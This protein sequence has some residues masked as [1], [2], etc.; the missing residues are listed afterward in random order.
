[1][2]FVA[3]YGAIPGPPGGPGP[4]GERG[5]PGPKGDKGRYCQ[6]G[7]T[8]HSGTSKTSGLSVLC[9][10]RRSR[11]AGVTGTTRVV[12]CSNSTQSAEEGCRSVTSP[13]TASKTSGIINI[14]LSFSLLLISYRK[15]RGPKFKASPSHRRWLKDKHA[16]AFCLTFT[17]FF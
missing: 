10:F 6:R 15:E 13:Q 3:A 5:Y 8:S 16:K 11:T 12:H 9:V 4:R 7:Q 17:V 14:Q 2:F 1:M